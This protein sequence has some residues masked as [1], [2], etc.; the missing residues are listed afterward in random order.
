[1][2]SDAPGTSATAAAHNAMLR[3]A[4]VLAARLASGRSARA[5][6][7]VSEHHS[8]LLAAL[9]EIGNRLSDRGHDVVFMDQPGT[10]GTK[11]AAAI[12]AI[13]EARPTGRA[14]VLLIP[15]LGDLDG[16]TLATLLD[17]LHLA[18]R[19]G[20]PLGCIATGAPKVRALLGEKRS[21]AERLI[22]FRSVVCE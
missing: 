10:A 20:L 21:F 12:R 9:L 2:D 5:I 14:T 4:E 11:L 22:E 18:A 19:D 15:V 1:M 6:V 8:R 3:Q 17:N 7:L 13:A 16:P